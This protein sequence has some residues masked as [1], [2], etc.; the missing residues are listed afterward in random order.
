MSDP[1]AGIA[2]GLAAGQQQQA[3]Q[4]AGT[5]IAAG[6]AP[7]QLAQ[8]VS[9]VLNAAP[10]LARSP[11]LTVGVAASGNSPVAAAQ[12]VARGTNAI[13]DASAHTTVDQGVGGDLSNALNWF[14][15]H[16]ASPVVHDIGKAGSDAMALMN[17]PMSIVQ[18]E[19]RYLH[20]VEA[21]HGMD[22]AIMEGIV[23]AGAGVAST[24]AT[25]G[26][27]YAGV[28]GSEV[29]A[30][31]LGQVAFHDSWER[32]GAASYTDPHTHQ[33]V[34]LGRDIASVLPDVARGSTV[35]KVTSGLID[36][37]FD[38]NVGGT[39]VLG[40]MKDA[41]SAE[42]LGGLLQSR[43]GGTAI[44]TVGDAV[45]GAPITDASEIDRITKQYPSI[46]RAFNRI[47]TMS[48]ADLIG[49][50]SMA[51]YRDIFPQLAAARDGDEVGQVFKNVMRT[52]E[53][54]FTDRLPS[55]SW[56]RL[57]FGTQLRE[58]VEKIPLTNASG[59]GVH[60]LTRAAAMVNPANM[61]QRLQALPTAFDEATKSISL[62]QFD[63]S[64]LVDDGT[65]GIRQQ[66]LFTERPAVANSVAAAYHN[67]ADLGQKVLAF[68]NISL[69]TLFAAGGLRQYANADFTMAPRVG[70]YLK[71]QFTDPKARQAMAKALDDAVGGGMFG[72]D[73]WYGVDDA[74]RNISKV[75]AANGDA[76]FAAAI[77]K[78][79]TG[80]LAF[81]DLRAVR[82]AGA[83]L[84]GARDVLGHID[85]FGY[86]NITQAI[87]KPIVLLTPS[88]ALHISL[89]ELIP[90]MLR[91]GTFKIVKSAI[92]GN[93][94]HLGWK[95]GEYEAGTAAAK[96]VLDQLTQAAARGAAKSTIDTLTARYE[97]LLK[98]TEEKK[99]SALAGLVW[100]SVTAGMKKAPTRI[101]ANLTKQIESRTV[102]MEAL[103]GDVVAPGVNSGHA[104][105]AEYADREQ[106]AVQ[107]LRRKY[108]QSPM[109]TSTTD[110][111]SL[112]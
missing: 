96:S 6:E 16:V 64:S 33:Q 84:A 29:A 15:D 107:L 99:V 21:T 28:L 19:Y 86:D 45:G 85:D 55:L 112:R 51:P 48:E 66:L 95:I 105:Q 88:Y 39:E 79:Q 90:N 109:K 10:E 13:S 75:K 27:L 44:K 36:G 32:T 111:P 18:H 52:Q 42:G 50:P 74:S 81:L 100:D 94:A 54:A 72:K 43:W 26:N 47:G 78:N 58:A 77:W 61:L 49:D 23:I 53:L 2:Q 80:K 46:Q 14:G 70:D 62:H 102:M 71:E 1:S 93:I 38:M 12:A 9:T 89:A 110:S 104:Y 63:P 106:N 17:K 34:S 20:D 25:G 68:R 92:V 41:K 4:D 40:L 37:L 69:N 101:D 59:A 83:Q 30:G 65:R 97:A 3:P 31:A 24:V 87:F 56:T 8:N 67:M 91:E 60:P 11:G 5:T 82:R 73:A 22:A 7:S 76:T 98:E 35:F 57:H 108:E 103:D